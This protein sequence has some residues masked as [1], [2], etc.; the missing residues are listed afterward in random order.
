MSVILPPSPGLAKVTMT[1]YN[2]STSWGNRFFVQNSTVAP[3]TEAQ[4]TT[5]ATDVAAALVTNLLPHMNSSYGL[6]VVTA[7]DLSDREG[8]FGSHVVSEAATGPDS[9]PLPP[10]VCFCVIQGLTR[11]YRGGRPRLYLSG[12]DGVELN[13]GGQSWTNSFLS[14]IGPFLIDLFTAVNAISLGGSDVIYWVAP[15]YYLDKVLRT[16]PFVQVV[17]GLNMQPR[18]CSQ[19]KR[20]GKSHADDS[21]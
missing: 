12:F 10:S 21:A 5:I 2:S 18:V 1:W 6:S 14:T 16:A 17:T 3:Y 9:Q 20:L 8:R 11:I 7:E 15:S 19:R 4:L 13:A